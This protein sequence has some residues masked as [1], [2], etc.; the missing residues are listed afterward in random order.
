MS[1]IDLYSEFEKYIKKDKLVACEE[2]TS[3]L[4]F[5]AN[6]KL[7]KFTHYSE[8]RFVIR[9]GSISSRYFLKRFLEINYLD[10]KDKQ[11]KE[12]IAD[13][14]LI[15]LPQSIERSSFKEV[16]ENSE[17]HKK[18][19]LFFLN[20]E[21]NSVEIYNKT[22]SKVFD[23]FKEFLKIK[24]KFEIESTN[25]EIKPNQ[26]V[27]DEVTKLQK[28]ITNINEK[29]E[30]KLLHP[31]VRKK[32]FIYT[33]GAVILA[34]IASLILVDLSNLLKEIVTNGFTSMVGITIFIDYMLIIIF[35]GYFSWLK[36][37]YEII[38]YDIDGKIKGKNKPEMFENFKFIKEEVL[39]LIED[40]DKLNINIEIKFCGWFGWN[41][42]KFRRDLGR[43][44]TNEE[45]Q[46]YL[47]ENLNVVKSITYQNKGLDVI[48]LV[49]FHKKIASVS[50][51]QNLITYEDSFNLEDIGKKNFIE[52]K[53]KG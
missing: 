22:N 18:I 25:L 31:D 8:F 28:Q 39:R 3:P 13:Y 38:S 27:L 6:K 10:T 40:S 1:V 26:E 51:A 24:K 2:N 5:K 9:R 17:V 4:T 32:Q 53:R 33:V 16:R 45:K 20:E 41:G 34:A 12:K 44:P 14:V 29:I 43:K 49:D 7:H 42:F 35:F 47:D 19:A 48:I 50:I 36:D 15:V 11:I 21:E 23:K 46:V 52:Y 30:N 37:K